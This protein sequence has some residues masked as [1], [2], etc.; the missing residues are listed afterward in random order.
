MTN[1]LAVWSWI[2]AIIGIIA[3]P[4]LQIIEKIIKIQQY[5]YPLFNVKFVLTGEFFGPLTLFVMLGATL[6]G[7]ILGVGTS[8][9]ITRNPSLTGRW[10]ATIG[11]IL[12]VIILLYGLFALA[13]AMFD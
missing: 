9:A 10:H 11:V 2:L 7:L 5:G 6:L 13:G 3:Y 1:K 12:N 4:G 8:K